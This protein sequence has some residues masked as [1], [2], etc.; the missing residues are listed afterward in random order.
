MPLVPVPADIVPAAGLGLGAGAAAGCGAAVAAGSPDDE[1]A[2]LV[3]DGA[4]LAVPESEDGLVAVAS[5]AGAGDAEGG[6][7]VAG[8][9]AT[10]APAELWSLLLGAPLLIWL[11]DVAGAV[12]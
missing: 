11:D 9:G 1:L 8:C 6:G 2:V 4:A 3:L 12:T 5:L 10:V 7:T